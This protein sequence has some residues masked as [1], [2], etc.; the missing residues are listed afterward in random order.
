GLEQREKA[1][2]AHEPDAVLPPKVAMRE[3]RRRAH[4]QVEGP[5]SAGLRVGERVE[6]EDDVGVA[7]G[8][9]FVHPQLAAA[10]RR[11][12]VDSARAIARRPG[13]DVG[14]L[15]PVALRPR[16]LV[17]DEDLRLERDEERV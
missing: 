12:P 11:A 7:L 5:A 15:D 6:K 13:A 8:A 17:P 3:R 1:A 10:R 16:D 2:E 9:L 14:E 4:A